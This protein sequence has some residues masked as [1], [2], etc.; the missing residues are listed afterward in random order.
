MVGEAKVFLC[1]VLIFFPKLDDKD[2]LPPT[3]FISLGYCLRYTPIGTLFFPA[4][5]VGL[6]SV[7]VT[8]AGFADYPSIVF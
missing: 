7:V 5:V 6:A 4:K 8:G 2:G 1:W 3:G